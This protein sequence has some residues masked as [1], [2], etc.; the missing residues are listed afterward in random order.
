M[1]KLLPFGPDSNRRALAWVRV[2]DW[3]NGSSEVGENSPALYCY[4]ISH[5][6]A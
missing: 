4:W 1:A 3:L 5:L 6:H 2:L